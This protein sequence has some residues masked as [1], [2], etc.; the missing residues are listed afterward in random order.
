MKPY[1]PPEPYAT[2]HHDDGYFTTTKREH[3]LRYSGPVRTKAFTE[4]QLRAEVE[5]VRRETVEECA[6]VCDAEAADA[7][8]AKRKPL[9]TPTG[10]M[11]YEGMWGGASNCAASIRGLLE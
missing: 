7:D 2:L 8:S 3:D 11:L 5:R 9:L 4:A 10:K 6:K 1:T